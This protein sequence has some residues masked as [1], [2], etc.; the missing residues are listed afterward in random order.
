MANP[1]PKYTVEDF[2]TH[3]DPFPDEAE[4][5]RLVD[6]YPTY[7]KVWR[8]GFLND[9]RK[10]AKHHEMV[11]GKM[12]SKDASVPTPQQKGGLAAGIPAKLRKTAIRL[13]Y[14]RYLIDRP[15]S[16]KHAHDHL[17]AN[18]RPL[19]GKLKRATIAS[20]TRHPPIPEHVRPG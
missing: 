9:L 17:E 6:C 13:L 2:E 3:V 7:L 15:M 5:Q 18:H 4:L 19:L 8:Q 16:R 20:Y 14:L 12:L 10:R 1:D 11:L